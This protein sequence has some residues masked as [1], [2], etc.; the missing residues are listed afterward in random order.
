MPRAHAGNPPNDRRWPAPADTGR[1]ERARASAG[2]RGRRPDGVQRLGRTR[3]TGRSVAGQAQR[4]RSE[5]DR[6][7]AP[8]PTPAADPT[9][10]PRAPDAAGQRPGPRRRSR[11]LRGARCEGRGQG[12]SAVGPPR[13]RQSRPA[14]SRARPSV[15]RGRLPGARS[16]GPGARGLRP[17]RGPGHRWPRQSRE[18]PGE[19]VGEGAGRELCH[20]DG[21]LGAPGLGRGQRPRDQ[22]GESNR[23]SVARR[24]LVP[25]LRPAPRASGRRARPCPRALV[26]RPTRRS[27]EGG[28]FA[29]RGPGSAVCAGRGPSCPEG[30]QPAAAG[31]RPWVGHP[32]GSLTHPG[33]ASAVGVARERARGGPALRRAYGA[34]PR[35]DGDPG[36][37]A[38]PRSRSGGVGQWPSWPLPRPRPRS[39]HPAIDPAGPSTAKRPG[40]GSRGIA[41]PPGARSGAGAPA[42]TPR[43]SPGTLAPPAAGRLAPTRGTLRRPDQPTVPRRPRARGDYSAARPGSA[44][45][46]PKGPGLGPSPATAAGRRIAAP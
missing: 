29:T 9:T 20:Q 36:V 44:P 11:Q 35:R 40:P 42:R 31:S 19:A 25:R 34:D 17:S 33:G 14:P 15:R 27:S 1:D 46:V 28:P 7:P 39:R 41:E 6:P 16:S 12:D 30:C 13:A 21:G 32:S 45:S 3:G 38:G 8:H 5:F 24:P 10:K 4:S 2:V 43:P 37:E 26:T 18:A 23:G 22:R